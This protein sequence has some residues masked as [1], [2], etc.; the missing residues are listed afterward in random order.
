M[1]NQSANGAEEVSLDER[2]AIECAL[3][4]WVRNVGAPV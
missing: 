4:C 1:K 3:S 2:G